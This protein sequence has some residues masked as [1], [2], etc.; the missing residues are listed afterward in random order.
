[1]GTRRK[2][3]GSGLAGIAGLSMLPAV[4][5]F[6]TENP[7]YKKQAA[8][9]LKLRFAI[10]SDLHYAQEGTDFDVNAANVVKWLSDDHAANHLDLVIINGDLVH[11][12]PDLLPVVKSKYFDKLPVPYY[13]IPGNHDF[14][15]AA[16]WK[17][18]FGYE[19]KYTVEHGDI[20]FVFANTADVKGNYIC[21]DNAFL[22]ASFEKFADKKIIFVILHI[23]P[24]QWLKEE[25]NT[26]TNCP[27]TVELLLKYPNVKAAFHGHDHNLDG[28]RYTGKLPHF[29]DSHTGGNWGTDYKGYR[30]VKVSED[31]SI[32]TYQVNASKNPVLNA[33]KF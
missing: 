23:A 6:A 20:A 19:D 4:N 2:F 10:A 16:V 14:A 11:N 7:G 15:D 22:E 17:S 28:V 26:F 25:A 1:M 3:I 31:N 33:D 18:V 30:V 9:K 12:R 24:I 32:Y 8:G 13:T 21:P 5:A 27:E 29:F